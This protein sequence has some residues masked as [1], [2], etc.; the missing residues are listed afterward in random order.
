MKSSVVAILFG[1]SLSAIGQP[2]DL[3]RSIE[4]RFEAQERWM[5]EAIS[6]QEEKAKVALA[7][8]EKANDKAEKSSNERFAAVNEFRG[9]L[10]DQTATFITR[11]EALAY[12][13]AIGGLMAFVLKRTKPAE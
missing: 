10:K 8:A 1:L 11:S 12:M 5:R 4:R 6:A 9:Q 3:D 7:A 2:S 13:L